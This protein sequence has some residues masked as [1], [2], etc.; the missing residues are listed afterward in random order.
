[1]TRQVSIARCPDYDPDRVETAF[2]A[3][4]APL[5]GMA[6]FV[7][8]GDRVL[9]KPNLLASREPA[10][11]VTTHPA[12]V[13]AALRAVQAA[14]GEPVLG[15][16]PGGRNT[17]A[18]FSAL[19]R[20]TGLAPVLEECGVEAVFFDEPTT[21][22]PSPSGKVYKRFRVSGAVADAD[23]IVSLSKFKTHQFTLATGAVK[24]CFGYIPGV[25]KAEYHLNTGMDQRRFAALLLDLY[26]ARPPVLSVMDAVL[27]ME[28]NGPSNGTV[29]EVGL[30]LAA[31]HAPD[32]DFLEA[33]LMGFD[34]LEVPTVAEAAERGLGPR[35]AAELEVLGVPVDEAQLPDFRRP[36]AHGQARVPAPILAAVSRL[37]AVRPRVDAD[38][39][40]RCGACA[41]NCPPGAIEVTDG[42]PR[43]RTADCIRCFCCQEL[44]PA[45]AIS[46]DRP[47]VRRLIG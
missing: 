39:C 8:P 22:I 40:R 15:D 17:P 34:P 28:G 21:E 10:K 12:V 38:R 1:M 25:A 29:R 16:S 5:G 37:F 36:A 31:P 44:C 7:K 13:R 20:R 23:T 32:L 46:I 18:N 41:E 30:L 35:A 47:L 9:V 6:A 11:A 24:N 43:I 33:L 27:G 2:A 4:L 45:D 19:L 42:I 3:V 14:G 26:L